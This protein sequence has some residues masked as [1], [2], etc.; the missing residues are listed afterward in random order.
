MHVSRLAS[1]LALALTTAA[2]TIPVQPPQA[3]LDGPAPAP[4]NGPLSTVAE[5][6]VIRTGGSPGAPLV[7]DSTS[8]LNGLRIL[9]N[10]VVVRNSTVVRPGSDQPQVYILGDRVTLENVTVGGPD[11]GSEGVRLE[12]GDGIVLRGVRVPGLRLVDPT[13]HSDALQ[14]YLQ[15]PLTNLLIE[16]SYFDGTVT[17]DGTQA[18]ANGSQIDGARGAISGTIRRSTFAGGKYFSARYYNISGPLTLEAVGYGNPMTTNSAA[19]LV[20]LP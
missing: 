7:I 4:A 12:G 3:L 2:C 6:T 14:V 10:D 11:G 16:D 1:A 19:G 20:Q 17:G 9:A 18:T 8:F 5:E 15:R 13:S